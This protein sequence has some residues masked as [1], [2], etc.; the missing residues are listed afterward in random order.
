MMDKVIITTFTDPMMGLS[1]ESEPVFRK[2]ETH[3]GEQIEFQYNMSLLVDDV[4]RFT[5]LDDLKVSKEYALSKYLPELAKIYE[6]EEAIF[7]MPV[8]MQNFQLFSSEYTTSKPLNLAYK[9]AQLAD[10]EKAD[11]FL[12]NLRY[13]TIVTCLP[14]TH[15]DEIIKVVR[16]TGID[17]E[18]F[19]QY[20]HNGAAGTAL[21]KD[22]ERTRKLGIYRL[23]AYLI[24]YK[25]K[26]ILVSR[27]IG[28]ETFV[29]IINELTSGKIQPQTVYKTL[30]NVEDLINKHPLI[31]PIEL[32]EA[33][34]FESIDK[35]FAFIE[36]LIKNKKISII[37]VYHGWFIKKLEK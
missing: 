18:K 15:F 12:Y 33:Y 27:L 36:P 20:Y 7:G 19:L 25:D 1:Y 23:P 32:Q 13:A 3:F 8:N 26:K 28:Y 5:N 31:S 30:E 14:T 21:Q 34:D 16:Q 29:Q 24:T 22:L 9:A 6:Q 11:L 35:V 10:K 2:L 37:D 4:Y 17:E